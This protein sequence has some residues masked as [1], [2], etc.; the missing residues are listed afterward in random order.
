MQHPPMYFLGNRIITPN[1]NNVIHENKCHHSPLNNIIFSELLHF[2]G[3]NTEKTSSY[4]KNHLYN[5]IDGKLQKLASFYL[6]LTK[7]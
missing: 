4:Q 6:H 1:K 7:N 2:C 5:P 3:K